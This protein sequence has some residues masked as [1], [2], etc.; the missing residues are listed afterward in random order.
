MP[1]EP[2]PTPTPSSGTSHGSLP[3]LD[4]VVANLPCEF[5]GYVLEAEIAR[6]GMG[7]VFR[8]QQKSL[9]RTVALKVIRAGEFA[10]PAHVQRFRAEAEAAAHLEHPNI[11]PIY[12]VGQAQGRQYFTMKLIDGGSL[13]D[14]LKREGRGT[15][16]D[17]GARIEDGGKDRSPSSIVHLPSSLSSD[18]DSARLIATI[19][20]AVHYAHQRGILHRDLK[21]ANIL[22]DSRGSPHVSDFGIAKR[23]GDDTRTL[24]IEGSVVGTPSYMAPEQ[25]AGGSAAVTVA[26]DVYSLGAILYELITGAPPFKGDSVLQTLQDVRER[27][28]TRP[29]AVRRSIDRDL[30]TICLKCLE[31]DPARRYPSAE[32]LA[33][34]LDR[35]VAGEPISARPAGRIERLAKWAR[36]NPALAALN[37]VSVAA[38]IALTVL[39]ISAWHNAAR[40]TEAVKDLEGAQHQIDLKR[41]ELARLKT[42]QEQD[43]AAAEQAARRR[44]YR[45]DLRT[46]YKAIQMDDGAAAARLL[47]PYQGAEF[48][49]VRGFEWRALRAMS[50]GPSR[51]LLPPTRPARSTT[52]PASAPTT[53][54]T[55]TMM[56]T[57]VAASS[58]DILGLAASADGGRIGAILGYGGELVTFGDAGWTPRR[59]STGAHFISTMTFGDDGRSIDVLSVSDKIWPFTNVRTRGDVLRLLEA[60]TV[61]PSRERGGKPVI[62]PT[63][64]DAVLRKSPP[65]ATSPLTLVLPWGHLV[66]STIAASRDGRWLACAGTG[67]KSGSAL[68]LLGTTPLEAVVAIWGPDQGSATAPSPTPPRVFPTQ[69]GA[70]TWIAFTPDGRR[71]ILTGMDRSIRAMDPGS[72]RVDVLM[73]S[74][75]SIGARPALS[76]DGSSLAAP[77]PSGALGIFDLR[78][79]KL[80]HT[81][82]MGGQ[83]FSAITF[84]GPEGIVTS[85][86]DDGSMRFWP[87]NPTPAVRLMKLADTRVAGIALPAGSGELLAA[88]Q[89]GAV[90]R[91]SL[92]NHNAMAPPPSPP[93]TA[94]RS[95][96]PP[97]PLQQ[98]HA[99]VP[100]A[101]SRGLLATA[102]SYSAGAFP[103]AFAS[104]VYTPDLSLTLTPSADNVLRV[105]DTSSGAERGQVRPEGVPTFRQLSRN[106]RRALVLTESRLAAGQATLEVWDLSATATSDPVMTKTT[107]ERRLRRDLPAGAG[108]WALFD[109]SDRVLVITSA[110]AAATGGSGRV[111]V[112]DLSSATPPPPP[113]I[114]LRLS[115]RITAC[116]LDGPRRRLAVITS[117]GSAAAG[118]DAAGIG[119]LPGR[120]D[121]LDLQRGKPVFPRQE[122]PG[123]VY[124]AAFTPD[125][126]RLAVGFGAVD[127]SAA[128]VTLVDP[129]TG[130][131]MM[132]F[133]LSGSI[134]NQVAFSDDGTRLAA[135]TGELTAFLGMGDA[136]LYVWDTMRR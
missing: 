124:C 7:V 86:V 128:G 134:V 125:G 58:E 18:R 126:T 21:P 57:T 84:A 121:I 49:D 114:D 95:L 127:R 116:A 67:V 41:Q 64:P 2:T 34:D 104:V 10:G 130:E 102:A 105:R 29:S 31:K 13:A 82:P 56:A 83:A 30:E 36:R 90:H 14:R 74:A 53:T 35:W 62:V 33:A 65:L 81:L 37:I 43:I 107:S 9:G 93:A 97:G 71:L 38:I 39:G 91:F 54:T 20:R 92:E 59:V 50:E 109:G 3:P 122:L 66:A 100:Q 129:H 133:E 63:S 132:T 85:D 24:T 78:A 26:A 123:V 115:G 19:A 4:V 75:I 46:A 6:G 112:L 23:F 47:E 16:E 11:I 108:H 110:A 87:V 113:A 8:A 98:V 80:A 60:R 44:A 119:A 72:G 32:A 88:D 55:T 69:Q 17:P 77:L 27:E 136:T 45:S 22:L 76:P 96:P 111:E 131:Q 28:P 15:S 99:A 135:S 42:Q 101:G 120:L 94:E 106:G 5:A 25:A 70:V 79:G 40:R 48:D 12:E 1:A 52:A 68:S 103:A 73:P 89:R 61:L 117:E 118:A 51:L